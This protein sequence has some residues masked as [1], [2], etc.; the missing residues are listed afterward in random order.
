M[1]SSKTEIVWHSVGQLDWNRLA[2]C[3]RVR[4]KPFGTMSSSWQK[5]LGSMS[6]S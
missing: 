2:Q 3:R 1:S 4:Q 6:G 5:P